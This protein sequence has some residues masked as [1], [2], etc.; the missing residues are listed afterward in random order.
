MILRRLLLEAGRRLAERPEVRQKIADVAESAYQRAAPKVENASKHVAESF[1]ETKRQT[2][3][4]ADPIGFA[5]KFKNRL[6][7]PQD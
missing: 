5:R 6:L 1:Q 3:P 7:P 4:L 2:D